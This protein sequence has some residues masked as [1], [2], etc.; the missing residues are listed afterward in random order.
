MKVVYLIKL[1]IMRQRITEKVSLADFEPR[2]DS[3]KCVLDDTFV[4]PSPIESFLVDSVSYLD[5]DKIVDCQIISTDVSMVFNQS[6]LV[7]A[8]QAVSQAV[9]DRFRQV[10]SDNLKGYS[11]D[12]IIK[13][14]KPRYLSAPCEIQSWMS[15]LM[16]NYESL[17]A[18]LEVEKKKAEFDRIERE[19]TTGVES[20]NTE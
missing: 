6:R 9:L 20:S 8:G 13:V 4:S 10:A 15:Y 5:C 19:N 17:V 11:D 7:N 16:K 1:Y 18:Q 14:I 2:L 3:F 12:D